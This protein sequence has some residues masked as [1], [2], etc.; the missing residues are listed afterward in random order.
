MDFLPR[1]LGE[2]YKVKLGLFIL[3]LLLWFL[4]VTQRRHEHS[5]NIPIELAGL[6]PDKIIVTEV[7]AE[8][9]VKFQAQGRELLRMQFT[10][11]PHLRIDLSSIS[12]FY[13]FH[14]HPDMVIIPGGFN[15]EVLDIISPDSIEIILGDR[16]EL[17]LPVS[18]QVDAQ[19][20]AGYTFLRD[21]RISPQK[22][23]VIGQRSKIVRLNSIKTE[24][25]ELKGVKRNTE[26]Q[27]NLKVPY[28]HGVEIVPSQVKVLIEVERLGERS[29]K[30]VPLKVRNIPRGRKVVIDPLS[31]D[32]EVSGGMSAISG[33]EAD[34]ISAWANFHEYDITRGGRAPVHVDTPGRVNVEKI[35]P[36]EVRLIVRRE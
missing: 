34:S 27:L 12:H 7:P 18:L 19:P 20:A 14:L 1:R 4:V 3:A 29:I 33:L 31:V 36:A 17:K 11:Q 22:V 5:F 23:L 10:D 9:E 30:R 16:L 15:A 8:A 26:L 2:N 28:I 13:T 6:K 32:V 24:A 35:T 21:F 25:A